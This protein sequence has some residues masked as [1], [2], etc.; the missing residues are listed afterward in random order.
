MSLDNHRVSIEMLVGLASWEV[1][2][3]YPQG[4]P[5]RNFDCLT[6]DYLS[7][8]ELFVIIW[9]DQLANSHQTMVGSEAN[10]QE[11]SVV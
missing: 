2:F 7:E 11:K 4:V 5:H 10:H 9:Y 1:K 6:Q 3:V 8:I